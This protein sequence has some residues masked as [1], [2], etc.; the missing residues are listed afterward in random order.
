MKHIYLVLSMLLGVAFNMSA[1]IEPTTPYTGHF[2]KKVTKATQVV[3]KKTDYRHSSGTPEVTTFKVL[4]NHSADGLQF[5]SKVTEGK[6]S[7]HD[8]EY[9][10][11]A[12]GKIKTFKNVL[13]EEA[14]KYTKDGKIAQVVGKDY[15]VEYH[16]GNKKDTIYHYRLNI[17]DQYYVDKVDF[18]EYKDKGYW[19]STFVSNLS[20]KLEVAQ[21][22]IYTFD[23]QKRLIKCTIGVKEDGKMKETFYQYDYTE[24]GYN[25]IQLND[26]GF[27]RG[28][29]VRFNKQGDLISKTVLHQDVNKEWKKNQ[30]FEYTYTYGGETSNE[31][32]QKNES[33]VC[34]N[35]GSIVITSVKAQLPYAV[36]TIQGKQVQNG[37]LVSSE[38]VVPV[39]AGI[40]V[41]A[42]GEERHKVIVK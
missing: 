34:V 3:G 33:Q 12:D 19:V 16:Y 31:E 40:Y 39:S 38:T 1:M 42:V 41:V 5:T 35:N 18:V 8:T 26:Q 32:I 14:Y 7:R 2:S 9:T 36:Y 17:Y 11:Y 22:A 10:F 4:C 20:D 21:S 15:K 23:D 29:V 24:D 30:S 6:M 37:V 28:E 25:E 13:T 27:M